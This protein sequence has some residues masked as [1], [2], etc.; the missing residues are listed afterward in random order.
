MRL[1]KTKLLGIFIGILCIALLTTQPA[2]AAPNHPFSVGGGCSGP[3][4]Q[5]PTTSFAEY[6]SCISE[7]TAQLLG[8]D[9]YFTFGADN[10]ALWSSCKITFVIVDE[11]GS[12][13]SS[14]TNADCLRDARNSATN[15]H[16]DSNISNT[17]GNG[18]HGYFTKVSWS[19][20]YQGNFIQGNYLLS[21]EQ[22]V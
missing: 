2:Y 12:N 16:Y 20:V 9:A 6:G 1:L 10:A 4:T 21:P 3:I 14:S 5:G 13:Y 15:A 11:N 17:V 18:G 8:A 19:G 22:F 7:G